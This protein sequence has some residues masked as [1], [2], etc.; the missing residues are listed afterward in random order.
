MKNLEFRN[1]WLIVE[2]VSDLFELPHEPR[3]KK[4]KE[5]NLEKLGK[6]SLINPDFYK[7]KRENPL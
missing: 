6:K 3:K 7:N 4:K 1:S 2:L 5:K